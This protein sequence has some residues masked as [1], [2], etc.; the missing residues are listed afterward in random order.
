MKIDT[1]T[2]MSASALLLGTLGVAAS[3]LPQ[4]MLAAVGAPPLRGLSLAIQLLGATYIGL[5]MLNWMAR[6]NL[7]G[8]IYSRPVAVCN[9]AHFA[10]GFLAL[11]KGLSLATLDAPLVLLT[12]LYGVLAAL[13][14]LVVYTHPAKSAAQRGA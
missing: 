12:A 1:K 6:A 4:E 13:F 11:L 8:G 10:I 5:A 14:G 9:L 7:I 2:L 3:F